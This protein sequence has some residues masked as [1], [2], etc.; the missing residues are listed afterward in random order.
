MNKM[1]TPDIRYRN[2][3]VLTFLLLVLCTY[4][5]K[6]QNVYEFKDSVSS[7]VSERLSITFILGEDKEKGN[8][9]Y[10][11]AANYY[12]Y[13][14]EGRTEY[15]DTSCRSL[16]E[17]REYLIENK[18]LNGKPWGRINMVSHGNQWLGLSVKVTPK[19]KRASVERIQEFIDN[20]TFTPL[21]ASVIDE[22]SE[23]FIH[24]CGVG[25]NE[26]LLK[27]MA[28]VFMNTDTVPQIR[29]S[30]F[31][32]YYSSVKYADLVTETRKYEAKA[33][34]I[35]YRMGYRPSDVILTKW[36]NDKYQGDNIDWLAALSREKPRWNGDIYHYTFE[37][38]VKWVI[39]YPHKDSLPDVST[40]AKK[41][42]WIKKQQQIID[43]LRKIEIEPE[44]FNWWFRTVNVRNDDGTLSPAVWVKGYCT[45][46]CVI[47]PIV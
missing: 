17:V 34:T 43:D 46:L 42:Q 16:L 37:V 20:G 12:Q 39:K 35:N 2:N 3:S 4:P 8:P 47:Q 25:N 41:L 45:I 44:K 18:P 24:G 15:L 27:V 33:W 31:Y 30:K 40:N 26:E 23:I 36:L 6:G 5:G 7:D 21:P 32:E 1:R 29:A 13:S 38:P 28:R 11:E 9:Y 10:A 19:S 22:H 14:I